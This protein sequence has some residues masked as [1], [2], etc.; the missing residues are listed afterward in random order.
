[1]TIEQTEFAIREVVV[2]LNYLIDVVE[3][4]SYTYEKV[5]DSL[6]RAIMNLMTEIEAVDWEVLGR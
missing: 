6:H 3:S 2:A 4:D 5:P 1:M